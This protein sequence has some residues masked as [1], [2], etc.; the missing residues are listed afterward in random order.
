MLLQLKVD[1]LESLRL[2][3][4][5]LDSSVARGLGLGEKYSVA[6]TDTGT[7]GAGPSGPCRGAPGD[8]DQESC[9]ELGG[10]G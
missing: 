9:R 3:W 1:V 8:G 5:P 2:F 6:K 10:A 7:S 4:L